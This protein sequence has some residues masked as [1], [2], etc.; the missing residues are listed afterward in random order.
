MSFP[1]SFSP[2]IRRNTGS[3]LQLRFVSTLTL[4]NTT[5]EQN[6]NNAT[7]TTDRNE[8][9]IEDLYNIIQTSGGLTYIA[10]S[11]RINV[12]IDN[13]TFIGN[14]ASRNEPNDSRPVLL[15]PNGH[16]GAMLVRLSGTYNSSFVIRQSRFI[17][18]S[19]EVD[20]GAIYLT[21]SDE[22]T[23]NVVDIEDS[24]F[25]GNSV[26]EAA[27]GGVSINS[28]NFTLGNE[29]ILRHCMFRDNTGSA[30]GAVSIALYDSNSNSTEEPDGVLFSDCM[31][32]NNSAPN[33]GTAVGLFSLVHVDQVGFLVSFINW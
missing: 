29:M 8:T 21:Y 14:R 32:E 19:A 10:G 2:L 30:G 28:F 15:K 22:A 20:G 6:N 25:E 24:L 12:L 26:T 3:S 4:I 18:N 27:G 1:F 11:Q 9:S 7:P 16:G 31:F 13:C 5:F 33:E 23:N 17:Q